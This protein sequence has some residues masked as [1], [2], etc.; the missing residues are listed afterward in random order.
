MPGRELADLV[1]QAYEAA[2][3]PNG[4]DKLA[5]SLAEYFGVGKSALVIWPFR[6]PDLLTVV[7]HGLSPDDIRE[8]F[9]HRHESDSLFGRLATL[10]Q[11]ETCVVDDAFGAAGLLP[12][13]PPSRTKLRAFAGVVHA[14]ERRCCCLMLFRDAGHGEFSQLENETLR[15][16][17]GYFRCAIALTKHFNNLTSQQKTLTAVL[18]SAPR[19]IVTLGQNGQVTYKNSEAK[20]ILSQGDGVGLAEDSLHFVDRKARNKFTDFFESIHQHDEEQTEQPRLS[21]VIRR[22]SNK[23][24]YQM[25]AYTLPFKHIQAALNEDEALAIVIIQDP[26]TNLQLRVELLQTFYNLSSAEARLAVALYKGNALPAAAASL[27][28]SINT[29][30]SQLRAIFKKIGVTSQAMLLQELTA[31]AKETVPGRNPFAVVS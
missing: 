6:N 24:P 2:A 26:T 10:P 7:T 20:R 28:I 18:N 29:A 17:M 11:G 8:R 25:M 23:P 14:N 22:R 15:T 4:L 12:D 31:S 16:L 1:A 13:D 21:T 27:H 30:R 3:D 9:E 5:G 19:G